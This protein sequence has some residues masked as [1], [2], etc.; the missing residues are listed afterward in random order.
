MLI[1]AENKTT[2][3][4]NHHNGVVQA[5]YEQPY[6]VSYHHEC[7][8][9]GLETLPNVPSCEGAAQLPP[10]RAHRHIASTAR[11]RDGLA[12]LN[13]PF[14]QLARLERLPWLPQPR[15]NVRQSQSSAWTKL[16]S[17]LLL[18]TLPLV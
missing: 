5:G 13:R 14:T 15:A 1:M 2:K 7:A 3:R 17:F 9:T 8:T 10:T 11:A 6:D 18:S 16:S 12:G 4:T